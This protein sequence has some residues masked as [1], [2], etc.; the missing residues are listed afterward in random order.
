MAESEASN[1]PDIAFMKNLLRKYENDSALEVESVGVSPGCDKGDNYM[2]V[3]N[4]LAVTGTTGNGLPYRKSFIC[5]SL[6]PNEYHQEIFQSKDLFA[7]EAAMYQIFPV[8]LGKDQKIV[9]DCLHADSQ[10]I[11][12]EDLKPEGFVLGDRTKGLN[13][14]HTKLVL[15][16]L[17]ELHAASFIF[18]HTEPSRFLDLRKN[19]VEILFPDTDPPGIGKFVNDLPNFTILC[20]KT[21]ATPEDDNSKEINFMSEHRGK[22]Y[23]VVKETVK[24]SKFSAL[25]A[26]DLWI[27]NLLFKYD[28]KNGKL[29]LSDV[30][31][32]DFQV[33]RYAPIVVDILYFFHTSVQHELLLEK[34]DDFLQI[35]HT[36]LRSKL[37]VLSAEIV[38]NITFEW[39]LSEIEKYKYYGL[40]MSLWLAPAAMMDAEDAPNDLEIATQTAENEV[41]VDY[42]KDKLSP[43]LLKRIVQKCKYFIR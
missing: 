16:T 10:W 4:R 13:F 15:E 14:E 34:M 1:K 22:I 17:A 43:R 42:W 6:P 28:K 41:A 35:Y 11:I 19:V 7:N 24:P 38:E 8:I 5:K 9:P 20:L 32:L 3:I 31:F 37:S 18:E 25:C 39:L 21:A 40:F 23:D 29:G 26:G 27:N 36:K 33:S 30:R 12:L 2:S